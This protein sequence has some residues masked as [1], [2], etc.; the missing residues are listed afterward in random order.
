MTV[1]P[2]TSFPRLQGNSRTLR[3]LGLLLLGLFL[4]F[5]LG[6]PEGLAEPSVRCA[7]LDQAKWYPNPPGEDLDLLALDLL[8]APAP[9]FS[10]TMC[11]TCGLWGRESSPFSGMPPETTETFLLYRA[12]CYQ[13]LGMRKEA[14]EDCRRILRQ[15]PAGKTAP[16][17]LQTTLELLFQQQ[18]Y[19]AAVSLFDGLDS[20]QREK[21]LPA[22]LYLIAQSLYALGQDV[23]TEDLLERIPPEAEVYPYA[24]YTLAQISY[25]RGETDKGL[26][27]IRLVHDAPPEVPVPEVLREMA[28]LTQARML[29][30]QKNYEGSIGGFRA[31]SQSSF[32]LP[33][34]LMGM[35]WCYRAIGDLPRAVS[36]F[37]AVESS[38]ADADTMTEA[39]LEKARVYGEAGLYEDAFE[40]YRSVVNDLHF[41][42]S[43]YKKYG[44]DPEWLAWLAGRLLESLAQRAGAPEAAPVMDQEGKLPEEMEPLLQRYKYTSPRM[45]EL[46]GIREGLVQVAVLFDGMAQP[47]SP[48]PTKH[49]PASEAYPPLR[50][51]FP[52]LEE[53]LSGL[54]DLD[55]ALLDTEYRLIFS[56]SMLGLLSQAERETLMQDC[57][58]FHRTELET[59]LLSGETQRNAYRALLSLQSTVQH[60]PLT[61]EQRERVLAKLVY[62]TR[63]LKET[64]DT[65]ERWAEGVGV[66]SSSETQPTRFLLLEKWMTLV[67]AFLYL[68]SWDVR[69]PPVFLL[70]QPALAEHRPSQILPPPETLSRLA[71]RIDTAWQRLSLLVER[72]VAKVHAERLDAL[73]TLLARTQFDYAEA[74][75]RQQERILENL[76]VPPSEEGGEQAP[77]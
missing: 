73:E 42:I 5:P 10:P 19:S 4:A 22:S 48:E 7:E 52:L 3:L 47:A 13:A 44:R 1:F 31:L 64:E 62:T 17:A 39:H 65:L 9:E 59:L 6:A 68:R 58:A 51:A 70:D 40:D 57:L 14:L 36:Y 56:G 28:W 34:A 37:R 26:L 20:D 11:W 16:Q 25:R 55:L 63:S 27:I 33:E 23:P 15:A 66:L 72:E 43:Q 18:N 53:G 8:L 45:K 30:Q 50:V 60:L 41:R 76:H 38:Y 61:L 2:H 21:L 69:S 54:L 12:K 46:F 49:P 32:F 75:V 74:L 35:A 29:F 77:E 71:Q 24:L 67:R